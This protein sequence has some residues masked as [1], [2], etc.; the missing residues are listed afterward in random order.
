MTRRQTWLRRPSPRPRPIL[1]DW[2]LCICDDASSDPAVIALLDQAAA[3]DLRIILTWR[4]D[5]G[6]SRAPVTTPWPPPMA[7]MSPSST[8][9]TPSPAT[10]AVGGDGYQQHPG[11]DCYI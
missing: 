4:R 2:Q 9:T 7:I 10:L 8:A 3:S 5:N 11:D 1:P 6:Y